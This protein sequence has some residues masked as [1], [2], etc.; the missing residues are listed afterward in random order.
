MGPPRVRTDIANQSDFL[1]D[2]NV[3][4]APRVRRDFGN[5]SNFEDQSNIM[6]S[7]DVRK[8]LGDNLNFEDSVNVMGPVSVRNQVGNDKNFQDNR[9][10]MQKQ[11]VTVIQDLESYWCT[12]CSRFFKNFES[13]KDHLLHR[14]NEKAVLAK[15]SKTKDRVKKKVPYYEDYNV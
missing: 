7:L 2:T 15:R 6:G 5:Q 9:N 12:K 1:D 4:G 14:H 11:E 13:L 8:D 10:I 3:M